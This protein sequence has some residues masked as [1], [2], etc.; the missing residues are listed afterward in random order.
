MQ[1][2]VRGNNVVPEVSWIWP[3]LNQGEWVEVGTQI[4]PPEVIASDIV[5][6]DYVLFRKWDPDAGDDGDWVDLGTVSSSPYQLEFDTSTLR[7]GFNQITA[8]AY[9]S[10]GDRSDSYILL[11]GWR[12]QI[13][14]PSVSR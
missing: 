4:F 14:L 1:I 12:S 13:Y 8:V 3:D 6:V 5:A 10:S 7:E 11:K 2:E 9:D